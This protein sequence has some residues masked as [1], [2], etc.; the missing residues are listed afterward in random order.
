MTGIEI[1]VWRDTATCHVCWFIHGERS[2][3]VAAIAFPLVLDSL[4]SRAVSAT[5]FILY[6]FVNGQFLI[7]AIDAILRRKMVA[8]YEY[9]WDSCP[10]S[11]S[12]L[13]PSYSI[14]ESG[15]ISDPDQGYLL[16]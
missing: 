14:F 3:A 5:P 15:E 12:S 4:T 6:L 11:S 2:V 13:L 8:W 1:I 16:I 10:R 7:R 9:F